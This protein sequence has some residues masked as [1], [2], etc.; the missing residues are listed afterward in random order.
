MKALIFITVLAVT[1]AFAEQSQDRAVKD[2]SP[3][4]LSQVETEKIQ[5]R[6]IEKTRE[7]KI[8]EHNEYLRDIAR[9]DR[10]GR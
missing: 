9:F 10:F 3:E 4:Y 1:P 7:E 2:F 8:R 6:E 5:E